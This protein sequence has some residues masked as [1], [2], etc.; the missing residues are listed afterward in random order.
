MSDYLNYARDNQLEKFYKEIYSLLFSEEWNKLDEEV[1]QKMNMFSLSYDIS[2]SFF[3]ESSSEYDSKIKN[4]LEEIR[5]EENLEKWWEKIK[6]YF[7]KIIVVLLKDFYNKLEERKW[8]NDWKRMFQ[9]IVWKNAIK[10]LDKYSKDSEL[11]LDEDVKFVKEETNKTLFEVFNSNEFNHNSND[12]IKKDLNS[13]WFYKDRWVEESFYK[14]IDKCEISNDECD[15]KENKFNLAYDLAKYKFRHNKRAD[16]DRYFDHLLW[17][18]NFYLD[19]EDNPTFEWAMVALLHDII[20]DT[21]IDKNTLEYLFWETIAKWV[22]NLS[23]TSVEYLLSEKLSSWIDLSDKENRILNSEI[24]F[25]ADW[26]KSGF[27]NE[28]WNISDEI[29]FKE[30]KKKLTRLEKA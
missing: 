10:Y 1:K 13:K 24:K 15:D 17:V 11:N 19:N 29:V 21:D 14:I 22:E 25:F 2:Q 6:I 20:E 27:L 5:K 16:W 30:R 28:R 8:E 4:I 12:D 9:N 23:K 3:N 18:M 26:K 7:R